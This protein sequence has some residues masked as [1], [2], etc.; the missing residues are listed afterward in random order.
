MIINLLKTI[1]TLF[2]RLLHTPFWRIRW[3]NAYSIDSR[4]SCDS[5]S[6]VT[7][8]DSYLKSSTITV[9]G[10]NV[11]TIKSMLVGSSIMVSGC[12]NTVEIVNV[13]DLNRLKL[14]VIGNNCH[15]VID[16][17]TTMN[18]AHL[19]CMGNG[20]ELVIGK[21]CM[22]AAEIEVW[23]SDSHPISAAENINKPINLSKSIHIAD[24][25]WVAQRAC[26]LKGVTIGENAIVGMASVVTKDVPSSCIVAGNPAKVIKTGITWNNSHISV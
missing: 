25:V 17:G 7:I 8:S 1:S 5:Q 15:V 10:N 19:V 18:G 24:H 22:F 23:A 11:L 21:N 14:Q 3:S 2:D 20:N 16:E 4:I 26:I 9:K 6:V 13:K 12:N